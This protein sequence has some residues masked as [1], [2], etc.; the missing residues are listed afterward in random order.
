MRARTRDRDTAEIGKLKIPIETAFS[1]LRV[2]CTHLAH[3]VKR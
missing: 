3:V 2:D 1:R